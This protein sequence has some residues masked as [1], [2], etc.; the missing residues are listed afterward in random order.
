M[1][2]GRGHYVFF[3]LRLVLVL[4]SPGRGFS[5]GDGR[6]YGRWKRD[7]KIVGAGRNW[8]FGFL[9]RR[10]NGRSRRGSETTKLTQELA[11]R[12][13]QGRDLRQWHSMAN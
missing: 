13:E 2:I 6:Y 10:K 9:E 8:G 1:G 3:V 11:V 5:P 7:G 4:V 12:L